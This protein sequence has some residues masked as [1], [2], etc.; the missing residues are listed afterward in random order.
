MA[1]YRQVVDEIRD[2]PELVISEFKQHGQRLLAMAL[3]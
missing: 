1:T 3:A 2:V